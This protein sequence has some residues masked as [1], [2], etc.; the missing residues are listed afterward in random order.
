MLSQLAGK[1]D[2]AS[3][4]NAGLDAIDALEAQIGEIA[5]RLESERGES[6][7]SS[8]LDRAMTD[9]MRQIESNA[10]RRRRSS[11]TRGEDRDRRYARGFA[12]Q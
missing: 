1:L 9:L 10:R 4:P 11:G 8:P 7:E 12:A 5:R 6:G 2:T 3:Q